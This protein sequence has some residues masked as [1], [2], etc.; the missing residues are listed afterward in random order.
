[1][2]R[3]CATAPSE[4][5]ARRTVNARLENRRCLGQ[6]LLGLE[7]HPGHS[8]DLRDRRASARMSV[9]PSRERGCRR[10]VV[11]GDGRCSRAVARQLGLSRSACD[12]AG[13]IDSSPVCIS[14]S[15]PCRAGAL[16][17]GN[18]PYVI[19][20]LDRAIAGCKQASLGAHDRAGA[21]G[22]YQRTAASLS[23]PHRS[24]SAARTGAAQVVMMLA[25]GACRRL[26]PRISPE[27]SPR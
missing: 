24:I 3:Q 4:N 23:S 22:R 14:V 5:A 27:M 17:R 1:M 19:S 12:R 7:F 9:M 13:G 6:A 2:A 25:G 21:Q 10:I 16:D 20:L 8:R 26:E 11:L 18:A 15:F